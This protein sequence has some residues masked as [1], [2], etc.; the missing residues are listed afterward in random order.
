L[1]PKGLVLLLENNSET[2]R[3]HPVLSGAADGANT[4]LNRCGS[5]GLKCPG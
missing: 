4:S 1:P 2:F 3:R 5:S